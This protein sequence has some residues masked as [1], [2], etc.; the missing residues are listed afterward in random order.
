MVCPAQALPMAVRSVRVVGPLVTA[1]LAAGCI[2][3]PDEGFGFSA[4]LAEDHEADDI[5][6][7]G[8]AL[9]P[10]HPQWSFTL[11]TPASGF[12][13]RDMPRSECQTARG[14]ALQLDFILGAS[15]CRAD[16]E[17]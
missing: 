8:G 10:F 2:A 14:A 16:R 12:A 17:V 9:A 6:A 13:A 7:L 15:P 11:D 3:S 5:R 1:L 4:R